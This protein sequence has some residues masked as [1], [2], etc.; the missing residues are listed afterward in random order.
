VAAQA[1]SERELSDPMPVPDRPV[2]DL[3]VPPA[4]VVVHTTDFAVAL[5]T[6]LAFKNCL[7]VK[8]P[9]GETVHVAVAA[10]DDAAPSTTASAAVP[11]V[12]R[13]VPRRVRMRFLPN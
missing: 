4:A 6:I 13:T 9:P 12:S 1:G 8:D 10:M 5:S 11:A 3:N 2:P 7:P